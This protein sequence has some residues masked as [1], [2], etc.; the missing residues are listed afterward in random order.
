MDAKLKSLITELGQKLQYKKRTLAVAESCTGGGISH[1]ITDIAG[2]SL[3]F[4][5]GFVT[6]SNQSKINMLGL[7]PKT[8]E[9]FGAVSENTALE[10]VQGALK[11]SQVDIAIAVTGIAGPSGGSSDKPIGTVF[12]AWQNKNSPA[13]VKQYLFEGNREAIRQQVIVHALKGVKIP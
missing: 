7:N 3:W 13:V 12:I 5:C 11:K 2:S 10:M 6:Y 1:A 8:L 9:D 4:D